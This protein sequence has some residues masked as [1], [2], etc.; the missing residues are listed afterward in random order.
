MSSRRP[1]VGRPGREP[2]LSSMASVSASTRPGIADASWLSQGPGS[3]PGRRPG[4]FHRLRPGRL[5]RRDLHAPDRAR[6]NGIEAA[7]L[8]VQGYGPDQELLVLMN[9]GLRLDPDVVV[10][11]FCL[12]NDFAEAML[13]VSLYDGRTPKPRFQLVDGRLVLDDMNLRQSA[14]RRGQQWLSDYSHLFNRGVGPRAGARNVTRRPVA[15]PQARRTS[16]QGIRP[17]GQPGDRPPHRRRVP[18]ARHHLHPGRLPP[19]AVLGLETMVGRELHGVG[20]G[21]GHHGRRHGG[22]FRGPRPVLL[23]D[24]PRRGRSSEARRARDRQPG[25]REGDCRTRSTPVATSANLPER[26]PEHQRQD[27]PPLSTK[28]RCSSLDGLA[29]GAS[30]TGSD[31]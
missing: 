25:A 10:L 20:A 31:S 30:A 11:A 21:G 27:C 23:G 26:L 2:R 24:F 3:D 12:G 9:E 5:R 29:I 1:T 4:R 19:R 28:R 17:S 18:G 16:R 6:H 14:P 7:N 13:P 22:P 8:A 15:R